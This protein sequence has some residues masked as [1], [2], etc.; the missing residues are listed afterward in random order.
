VS[1]LG[2]STLRS[3]VSPRPSLDEL[4]RAFAF[5]EPAPLPRG[6]VRGRFLGFLDSP[7][8]QRMH[9]RA[10]D[11][12]LFRAL[13]WG[14]DFDVGR[15][16]FERPGLAAGRFRAVLGRSRWRDTNVFQLHYDVSRLPLHGALYDEVKPLADG[17]ILGLGGLNAPRGDGD[18]FFFDLRSM[19]TR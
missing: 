13:R 14:I 6:L 5:G 3:D 12:L 7:G 17:R 10:M 4:E 9:V 11:T 8:A 15:W 16:W 2:S 1:I 19:E 18:H